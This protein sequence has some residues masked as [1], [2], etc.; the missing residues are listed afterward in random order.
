[1]KFE[2][3]RVILNVFV[4]SKH[5]YQNVMMLAT[6]KSSPNVNMTNGLVTGGFQ[7]KPFR[8][9]TPCIS[10]LIFGKNGYLKK[11]LETQRFDSLAITS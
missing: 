7:K 2:S 5:R 4:K 8:Y 1:M 9:E 10:Y 6:Q 11:T 3:Y